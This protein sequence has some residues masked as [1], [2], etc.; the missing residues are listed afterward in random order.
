[1]NKWCLSKGQPDDWSNNFLSV[2]NSDK[3]CLIA[4]KPVSLKA[5]LCFTFMMSPSTTPEL[6]VCFKCTLCK[7]CM[8]L[9]WLSKLKTFDRQSL[10][11][12][13][14]SWC[15]SWLPLLARIVQQ[16]VYFNSHS[17]KC[18]YKPIVCW[19]GCREL[20]CNMCLCCLPTYC[21]WLPAFTFVMI[22]NL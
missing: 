18:T 11:V 9:N 20:A 3:F 22:Q 2:V 6:L 5:C 13:L 16:S 19:T 14:V 4:N 8:Q 7:L 21:F 12:L 10:P 1:M 17:V 15:A